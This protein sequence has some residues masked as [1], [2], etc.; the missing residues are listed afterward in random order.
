M[1]R[2]DTR[3]YG[4]GYAD[5]YD[6]WYDGAWATDEAVAFL[7][8]LAGEGPVLELAVGTG[9]LAVPLAAEGS[10]VVGVDASSSMFARLRANDPD[11]TVVGMQADMA[12]LPLAP[13]P[14]FSLAFVAVN[15]FFN[16]FTE[17]AQTSCL[18]ETA[19]VLRPGGALVVEAFVPDDRVDGQGMVEPRTIEADRVTLFVSRR[20]V[21][22]QTVSGQIIEITESGN[23]LRPV[24]IRYLTPDQLDTM[25]GAVGLH[26]AERWQDWSRTPFGPDSPTHVSV[27]RRAES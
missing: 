5:V 22:A 23:R 16:L 25:A 1:E 13:G 6:E 2:Y 27:Y 14:R 15:S 8:E 20:D 18:E 17:P 19:A 24:H 9:R 26:L 21:E 3:S 12:A 4:E 10:T 7:H 11:R